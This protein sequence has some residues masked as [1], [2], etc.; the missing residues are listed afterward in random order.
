MPNHISFLDLFNSIVSWYIKPWPVFFTLR[1][2]LDKGPRSRDQWIQA[3]LLVPRPLDKGPRP[4]DKW[5]IEAKPTWHLFWRENQLGR[6]QKT[7]LKGD[8]LIWRTKNQVRLGTKVQSN[9]R[10]RFA[11]NQSKLVPRKL[12]PRLDLARND[13]THFYGMV[14]KWKIKTSCKLSTFPSRKQKLLL[15]CYTWVGFAVRIICDTWVGFAVQTSPLSGA[16]SI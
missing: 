7:V 3:I 1:P 14:L 10:I 2:T 12:D 11:S 15:I 8:L 9:S 16:I 4:L 13:I 6:T 5:P